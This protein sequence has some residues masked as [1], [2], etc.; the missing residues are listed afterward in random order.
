MLTHYSELLRQFWGAIL[1]ASLVA[2]LS[3]LA[4][5]FLLLRAMPIYEASVTLNMQPSVEDLQFNSA[6]LGVSQFNPA[7]IIAQ[8]HIE[9]FLSRPVMERAVEIVIEQSGGGSLSGPPTAFDSLRTAF[10]R[11][12][13]IL[14][15]GYFVPPTEMEGYIA[16]LLSATEI[17]MVEG[18]YILLVTVSHTEPV[19][20]ARAA[21]ALALA[22]VELTQAD[23]SV[24]AANVDR[25]LAAVIE[26]TE[27]QRA[28][29]AEERRTLAQDLGV[30]NVSSE[31]DSL[32]T[33]RTQAHEALQ[34]ARGNLAASRAQLS[35]LQDSVANEGDAEVARQLR[36]TIVDV[37]ASIVATEARLSE[38]QANLE[39]TERALQSLD[40]IENVLADADRRIEAVEADLADLRDRRIRTDLAREARLSQVRTISEAQVPVYPAFPKV[41]VNTIAG[42]IVGAILAM[43]PIFAMDAL[44][45]RIKTSADLRSSFGSR[46]LPSI[47]P[48]IVRKAQHYLRKGGRPPRALRRYAEQ[49]GGRFVSEG[50]QRWPAHAVRVTSVGSREDVAQLAT[51]MRAVIQILDRRQPDDTP[52]DIEAL[53]PLSHMYDWGARAGQHVVIA[54]PSGYATRTELESIAGLTPAQS[55]NSF[56]GA[57]AKAPNG[58]P[59][60]FAALVL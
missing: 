50:Q 15:S 16:D 6:F 28:D 25:S 41:L 57:D 30:T 42:F 21:N 37:R 46:V 1:T 32:L 3:A 52:L 4:L 31:R 11:W 58:R 29:L 23:L 18:S 53:E 24:A 49:V 54:I 27:R 48:R 8:T 9:R 36:Q 10:F 5:S 55:Q 45:D 22:Y 43:V 38:R 47:G 35:E 7:T 56:L 39:N 33:A 12:L 59:S 44:G 13:R 2:G 34:Q 51:L 20:A 40:V 60:T 19:I 17:E 14:N 26:R